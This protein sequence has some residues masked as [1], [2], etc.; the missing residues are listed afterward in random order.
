[1]KRR[2]FLGSSLAAGMAGAL[3]ASCGGERLP[4]ERGPGGGGE[5]VGLMAGMTLE[6]LAED[7]RHRLFDLYL[8]FW[9][10][11]GY[12]GENGGF[13]CM[14]DDDGA[15]VEEEKRLED[16]G[17]ALW[18]YSFLYNNFGE[19]PEYLE[20]A[21]KTRNFMVKYM[22]AENGTWFERVHRDGRLKEDV[23]ENVFG[24]LYAAKGLAE[25]YRAARNDED[26][27]IVHETVW[28]AL[29][30]YDSLNYRGVRNYGGIAMDVTTTGL[31]E[32]GHSMLIIDVLSEFLSHTK[33]RRLAEL[34][35]EH[36]THVM[37]HFFNPKLGITNE[38]LRHDYSRLPGY[39]DYMYTGHAVETM[40]LV[41]FE[42][43]RSK[44]RV[45]FEDAKNIIRRYVEMGWDYV[46]EGY[47][48]GHFYVFD[49]PGRT[50]DRLYSVKTLRSHC[51]LMIALMSIYEFTGERWAKEWYERVQGY[52]LEKLAGDS[53]VWRQAVDRF[54][55]PIRHSGNAG[56]R[57][58]IFH[59][60]RYLMLNLLSLEGM[61]EETGGTEVAPGR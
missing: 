5:E 23:S 21:E 59:Q 53:I 36:V 46:F 57:K 51:N 14:V 12:D 13:M 11:G 49:G 29:R 19:N 32:L 3:T 30:A 55:R 9:R 39:E 25:F 41:L 31:R 8:P 34:L 40:W 47:G 16:Q 24:W 10:K 58:D 60:P 2:A 6:S 33:N 61:L 42:A 4:W 54:G 35:D 43:R 28:A 1:M 52:A 45:L 18:V 50:R 22:R 17:K 38:Y 37:E 44:D 27:N 20:I 26:R 56:T 7:Y 15:V 48:D